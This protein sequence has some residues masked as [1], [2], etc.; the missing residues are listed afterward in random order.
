MKTN[1]L[2]TPYWTLPSNNSQL[3]TNWKAYLIPLRGYQLLLL[4][5]LLLVILIDSRRIWNYS[6]LITVFFFLFFFYK[7]SFNFAF[8]RDKSV[9]PTWYPSMILNS[10]KH[11]L[12]VRRFTRVGRL[13]LILLFFFLLW[14]L[15]LFDEYVNSF[16]S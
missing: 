8:S 12:A 1:T 2:N 3:Q 15:F 4:L 7:N 14:W 16:F 11:K 10:I 5:L 6:L 9:I 13:F